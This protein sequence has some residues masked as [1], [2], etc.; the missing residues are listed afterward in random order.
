M[1]ET[2]FFSSPSTSSFEEESLFTPS[3]NHASHHGGLSEHVIE[4]LHAE[5]K[6]LNKEQKAAVE[7]GSGPLLVIAGAGSGKTKVA[8]L[9]IAHLI[10]KGVSPRAIIGVTFTNKA[11]KE[12]KERVHAL[13]GS[14][15]LVTTFHSLGARILREFADRI[16]YQST[17]VIYDEDEREKLMKMCL[18]RLQESQDT[19]YHSLTADEAIKVISQLKNKSSSELTSGVTPEIYDLFLMYQQEMKKASAMDFDDL[20]FKTLELLRDFPDVR[21]ILNRRWNYLLV[22]EYQDTNDV[23]SEIAEF[24]SGPSKNIF[25]VGDPDQSIYSWRGANLSHILSFQDRFQ[26]AQVI[27]LEQNYRSTNTI[28]EASNAVIRNNH[29]RLEK[30]LWSARGKGE[31]ISC[32]VART[33]RQEAEFVADGIEQLTRETDITPSEIAILY[34]TN[35]QSRSFEDELIRRRIPY[36]IW[37]GLSFYQRKEIKDII[38]YAR[39]VLLPQDTIAFQRVINVPKRGVGS[40][41]VEKLIAYSALKGIPIADL[42]VQLVESSFE[43][44]KFPQLDLT[45]TLRHKQGLESFSKALVL[46][47]SKVTSQSAFQLISSAIHDTGYLQYLEEEGEETFV[48]RRENLEQLLA[49]ASEWDSEQVETENQEEPMNKSHALFQFFETLAL[50]TAKQE[51]LDGSERVT[52]ATV[53]NAKGLEFT[54]VFLVGLEEDLFP[55]INVKWMKEGY[56]PEEIEE[57]RRLMYVGMTR[58]KD[59][60]SLSL[61][62]N[63]M[64]WGG[65]RSMRPSRF[66]YEVPQAYLKKVGRFIPPQSRQ[67][68]QEPHPSV[69]P[70]AFVSR[71]EHV[72]A[73]ESVMKE[74]VIREQF[75]IGDVV[76]HAVHG[77]GKIEDIQEGSMGLT[78]I[79]R[80]TTD[81]CVRKMV[82]SLAPLTRIQRV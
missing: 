57:E 52:L 39:L 20:Q 50:E 45:L 6:K 44:A 72:P 24:L 79:I 10:S 26:G 80:F 81:G 78:Y 40:T 28:L 14:T 7:F 47:R 61:S 5:M 46:M 9:R 58:A 64:L 34:R 71:K 1:D 33:E 82:A 49:K 67:K 2:S 66:L 36:V 76:F 59:F 54:S 63:R 56:N 60:L 35:A 19:R 43:K 4:K 29:K 11:A 75:A 51:A 3:Q 31:P 22:D 68:H 41:T 8:T 16:G 32:F 48:D 12:M 23:Q 55:H 70:K 27:R 65:H 53:H 77:L 25:A 38:S 42:I 30:N 73:P 69:A 13:L 18:K 62:Q 37:G 74:S 17:F 15:V 21:E